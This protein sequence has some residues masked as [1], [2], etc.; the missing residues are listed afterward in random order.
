MEVHHRWVLCDM[1]NGCLTHDDD[2]K[3]VDIQHNTCHDKRTVVMTAIS[4]HGNKPIFMT[5]FVN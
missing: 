3:M 5:T 2:D 4:C 1:C